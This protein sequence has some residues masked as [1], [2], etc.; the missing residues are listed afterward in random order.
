VADINSDGNL[1]YILCNDPDCNATVVSTVVTASSATLGGAPSPVRAQAPLRGFD[2]DRD[3][4]PIFVVH[5]ADSS[6]GAAVG[7]WVVWCNTR[8]CEQSTNTTTTQTSTAT[9]TTAAAV[10]PTNAL[11][12]FNAPLIKRGYPLRGISTILGERFNV[13]AATECGAACVEFGT[14]C[15]AFM[16]RV[17]GAKRF[18]ELLSA[19]SAE[20]SVSSNVWS[21]YDRNNWCGSDTEADTEVLNGNNEGVGT[22]NNAALAGPRISL[23]ADATFGQ[24]PIDT[25]PVSIITTAN[26][27]AASFDSDGNDADVAALSYP[28]LI[29]HEKATH[30]ISAWHCADHMCSS[31][32]RT[33]LAGATPTADQQF[34][35]T[36]NAV[37]QRLAVGYVHVDLARETMGNTTTLALRVI[38]YA[39]GEYGEPVG[40]LENVAGIEATAVER[41]VMEDAADGRGVVLAVGSDVMLQVLQCN[42]RNENSSGTPTSLCTPVNCEPP[43]VLYAYKDTRSEMFALAM[44]ADGLPIVVWHEY[45][46]MYG[47]RFPTLFY[48]R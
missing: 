29:L 9:T 34:G 22:E 12:H 16:T 39:I 38:A 30:V 41:I 6:N 37:S 40:V 28:V 17:S 13:D 8:T 45:N 43:T 32:S 33:V 10:C 31:A 27:A 48:N 1:V 20:S 42:C 24:P 47:A 18:C 46:Q 21:M 7:S 25:V 44:G 14:A 35:V 11:T 23:L 5:N 2:F 4:L 3:G 36:F 19:S 26:P 15:V